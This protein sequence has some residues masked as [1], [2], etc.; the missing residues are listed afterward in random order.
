MLLEKFFTLSYAA[1]IMTTLNILIFK[2]IKF[3]VKK[4]KK[5]IIIYFQN[6]AF[7]LMK[8]KNN[9]SF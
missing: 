5:C 6:L 9:F 4:L 8:N 1:N 2:K 3:S 7:F